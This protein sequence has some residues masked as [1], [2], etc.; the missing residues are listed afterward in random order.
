MEPI[1]R[2]IEHGAA[3]LF[4]RFLTGRVGLPESTLAPG[5]PAIG[6]PDAILRIGI[7][8]TQVHYSEDDARSA[9]DLMRD[10][11]RGIRRTT[12]IQSVP[13]ANLTFVERAQT[14]LNRKA[15]RENPEPNAL[16]EVDSRFTLVKMAAPTIESLRQAFLAHDSRLR[17]AYE[18]RD[19]HLVL[20]S[21]L[22]EP[23]GMSRPWLRSITVSGGT[24][25]FGGVIAGVSREVEFRFSPDLTCIIGGPMSGKSTL[26]DGIRCH[27]GHPLPTEGDLRR[28]VEERAADRFLSG[29][30]DVMQDICGPVN[31]AERGSTRWPAK[32]FT[33]R[34]LQAIARDQDGLRK[35]IYSLSAS[36]ASALATRDDALEHL[37]DRLASLARGSLDIRAD[38]AEAQQ[39]FDTALRSKEALDRLAA[40]NTKELDEA[41]RKSGLV[42]ALVADIALATKP[43]TTAQ[44]KV[45]ALGADEGLAAAQEL[46]PPT[47]SLSALVDTAHARL[48]GAS[49][50]L[51]ELRDAATTAEGLSAGH[52]EATRKA[53]QEKLVESGGSAEDLNRFAA[54]EKAAAQYEL[55]RLARDNK[56]QELSALMDDFASAEAERR[57]LVG[58]QRAEMA[59]L[60]EETTNRFDREIRIRV[61]EHG[62]VDS[63]AN[64]IRE[65]KERGLTRWWNDNFDVSEASLSPAAILQALVG[66]HL[67]E[68]GMSDQVA[69][70]FR[71][72]M[73]EQRRLELRSLR[74]PDKYVL[75]LKVSTDYRQLSELSGGR[76]LSLL[77][78][79]LL[80]G[81]DDSPLVIDQ[82]EDEIDRTY[83]STTVLP[84]L[85]KLKGRRQIILATHDADIVVNGDADQVIQLEADATRGA[86]AVAGAIESPEVRSA[87][88]ATLDGGED[89][90]GLRSRKYGF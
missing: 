49:E 70:T 39:S 42:Q 67:D 71:G 59:R 48:L 12:E 6:E 73:N 88:I 62:V 10:L 1:G 34:E 20:R 77:L 75:E 22:P 78:T 40:T 41:N 81:S 51:T 5:N 25:F 26:L 46:L 17:I 3:A 76:Q 79:L 80:E 32:F 58:L 38:S 30:A 72:V 15:A 50:S 33:Q 68:L 13:D 74:A 82:P 56:Q 37:D 16:F 9:F 84:A 29:G 19:G 90:F 60:A 4:A 44:A 2:R 31:P 54:L 86:V 64:W 85:R 27:F 61:I 45:R 23:L 89:A 83:L 21:D 69:D 66:G 14:L 55:A 8:V 63:I 53:I 24:S 87:I 43:V 18:K 35:L 28:D 11:D 36:G 52:A 47:A 65:Q 7:E 57:E